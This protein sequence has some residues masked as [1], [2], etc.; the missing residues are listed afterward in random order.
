MTEPDFAHLLIK[1][2]RDLQ[3]PGIG[4]QI[5]ALLACLGLAGLIQK[6]V[7]GWLAGHRGEGASR[8]LGRGGLRRVLFPLTATVLILAARPLL[9]LYQHVNLLSLA[10]PLL[11]SLGI[12]RLVM[13]L[14]RQAFRA[15][16]WLGGFERILAT[17][18]WLVVAL[19]ILGWLPWVI[20][21]LEA[22]SFTVGK[23]ELNLWLLLQGLVSV[24]VTLL[25]ALWLA[26]VLE[27][28]LLRA[29][30]MDASVRLVL[31]RLNKSVLVVVAVMVALPMVGI[32]LTTLSV[33]GGALGVGLGFGLQ[34]I[35][36]SYVSGFI[37]L[38]DRSIRMGNLISVG[39]ERGVVSQITTRY[40]VL[41][42]LNGVEV[43]VPNET[44][45]GSVVQNE[46][47]TN[48]L[49]LVPINVQVAYASNVEAVLALLEDIARAHPRALAEP[50]PKALLVAFGESG[51][52]LRVNLW[53]KD[54]Q[55]GTLGVV[56]EIN[57][58][59]W[60]RF[61]EEGIQIPY[62]QREVRVL[63][64]GVAAGRALS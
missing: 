8:E 51:I 16:S 35:A 15:S 6:G 58:A 49:V 30:G 3:T 50:P 18:A 13:Y 4:W 64:S 60:R 31:A 32:D 63:G 28:R 33:F 57:R 56:S 47:F 55:E 42:G 5:A 44:L 26:G 21:G 62:P 23:S 14:L 1:L 7:L 9:A 25:L 46:T 37:I 29:E 11:L 27:A 24:L 20:E 34:K 59:I 61:Q 19:H 40:T 53:I 36:A 43:I 41:R 10:L 54:P 38:L 45:V 12:V 17:C 48:S 52:D 39:T 2:W 22:I